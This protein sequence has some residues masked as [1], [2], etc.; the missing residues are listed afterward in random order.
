MPVRV[1]GN[2]LHLLTD[3]DAVAAAILDMA[4][5]WL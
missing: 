2:H 3:P 5:D 4:D 1:P